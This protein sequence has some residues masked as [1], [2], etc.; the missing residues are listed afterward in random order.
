MSES[1]EEN[2]LYCSR[3]GD[4]SLFAFAFSVIGMDVPVFN[5]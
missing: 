1:A 3:L 4:D 5:Q 2:S